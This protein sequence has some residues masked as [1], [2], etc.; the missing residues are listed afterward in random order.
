MKWF[1]YNQPTKLLK[2]FELPVSVEIK[3][4]QRDWALN[5][6]KLGKFS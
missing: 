1:S 6:L 4:F 2:G 5:F 3:K